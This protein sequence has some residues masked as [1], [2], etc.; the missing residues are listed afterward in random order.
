MDILLRVD[1]SRLEG[2]IEAGIAGCAYW[3]KSVEYYPGSWVFTEHRS[4][5]APLPAIPVSV[6]ASRLQRGV[7]KALEKQPWLLGAI[8]GGH[9]LDARAGEQFIQLCCFG[10]IR[11]A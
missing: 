11:Y 10:E 1:P 7:Q 2:A 5:T 3:C 9:N 6:N 4:L 8:L